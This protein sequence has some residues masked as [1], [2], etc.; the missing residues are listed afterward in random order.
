MPSHRIEAVNLEDE[1]LLVVM[2]DTP[3]MVRIDGYSLDPEGNEKVNSF[4][5]LTGAECWAHYRIGEE[6][7]CIP[8]GSNMGESLPG[9]VINEEGEER[10]W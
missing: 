3:G 8:L 10:E 6:E 9:K 2:D 5:P 1:L 4:Y 7:F